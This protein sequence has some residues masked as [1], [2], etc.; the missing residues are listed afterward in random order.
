MNASAKKIPVGVLGATGAV[1]QRMV[2]LLAGHP[3][4]TL[5][6]LAASERSAGKTYAQAATWRLPGPIPASAAEL[7]VRGLAPSDGAFRATILFSALDASVAGEVEAR[8]AGA[9]HAVVSNSKNHRMTP[10]VP[11]VIPE[12]N[13]EHLG[14]IPAQ[15]RRLGGDGLHRHES[16]LLVDRPDDGPRAAPRAVR[17]RLRR[18]RDPAGGLRGRL[19]GTSLDGH[20]RQRR[21]RTSAARRR[22]SRSSRARCSGAWSAGARRSTR[23]R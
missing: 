5:V 17:R 2:S 13:H 11:L 23:R 12:V 14:L 9:G 1:G 15:R 18:R 22:R 3:W 19:S 6:E 21:A 8:L 10:D 16:Q 20:P 4:F 7:P